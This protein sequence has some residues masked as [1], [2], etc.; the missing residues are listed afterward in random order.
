[1]NLS[2]NADFRLD[3]PFEQRIEQIK[4]AGFK[5]VMLFWR[6]SDRFQQELLCVKENGLRIE[7]VHGPFHMMNNL[8]TDENAVESLVKLHGAID[9]CHNYAIKTLVIHPTDTKTPPPV[10]ECGK[11]YFKGL[12]RYA[13]S[14]NVDLAFENIECPE[15]L[16]TIFGE[17]DDTNVKLCY[18]VGH[19]NCF[20][21]SMDVLD[22]YGNRLKTL[23]IHDNDGNDDL[24]GIPFDGNVDYDRFIAKLKELDY[25]GVISLEIMKPRWE[26]YNEVSDEEYLARAFDAAKRLYEM[27]QQ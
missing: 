24:H 3:T 9:C 17:C 13:K 22:K 21:N 26:R 19:E 20:P 15:Y 25:Y 6:G 2:I 11:T 18:D 5:S 16:D 8:W 27:R 1:M 14:M 4:N 7:S 23:H 12:I 10:S